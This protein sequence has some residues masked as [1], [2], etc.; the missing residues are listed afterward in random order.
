MRWADKDEDWV[1]GDPRDIISN[2]KDERVDRGL[3]YKSLRL[4][5]SLHNWLS[6][7]SDQYGVHRNG[8]KWASVYHTWVPCL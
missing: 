7:S 3:L 8:K 5:S 6:Y 2:T 4:L 1:S